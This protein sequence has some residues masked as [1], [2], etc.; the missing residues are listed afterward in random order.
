VTIQRRLARAEIL[1]TRD[2]PLPLE[3][4]WDAFADED[5]KLA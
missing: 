4:V 5:Q 3:R 1:L 2:Y